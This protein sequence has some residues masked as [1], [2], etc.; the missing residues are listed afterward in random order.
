[1]HGI[2]LCLSAES[3]A[4]NGRSTLTE[5][6]PDIGALKEEDCDAVLF[7]LGIGAPH[8]DTCVRTSDSGI[9]CSLR[10]VIG[11]PVLDME[12]GCASMSSGTGHFSLCSPRMVTRRAAKP[13]RIPSP[14]CARPS[15]RATCPPIRARSG[16]RAGSRSGNWRRPTDRR[17][18]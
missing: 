11:Q 14:R 7:D 5:L 8:C 6:G 1:M 15:P 3:G 16:L 9:L 12:N 17:P 10:A 13:G 2:A 4:M 18:R